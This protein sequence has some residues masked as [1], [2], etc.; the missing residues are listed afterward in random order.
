MRGALAAALGLIVLE[1]LVTSP[2]TQRIGPLL[3]TP[4]NLVQ[5]IYD[6]NLPALPDRRAT[7]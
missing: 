6:P 1:V 5:R 7:S 4:A 2:Q 3:A